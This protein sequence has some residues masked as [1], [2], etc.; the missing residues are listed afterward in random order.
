[1]KNR[2]FFFHFYQSPED[3]D[4]NWE[5]HNWGTSYV[6]RSHL[7]FNSKTQL[8]YYLATPWVPPA[9]WVKNIAPLYPDLCFFMK[10]KEDGYGLFGGCVAKG[11]HFADRIIDEVLLLDIFN[12]YL[13][14]GFKISDE[15]FK[16]FDSNE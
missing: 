9:L 13:D 7:Y 10:Y 2:T 1:M 16:V 5:E 3:A 11:E 15:D 6:E 8:Y 12:S 14:I 4:K